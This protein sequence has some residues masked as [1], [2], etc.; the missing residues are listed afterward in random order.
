MWAVAWCGSPS[1]GGGCPDPRILP[2]ASGA[3]GS[4][5][6][7]LNLARNAPTVWFSAPWSATVLHVAAQDPAGSSRFWQICRCAASYE[8]DWMA[9]SPRK[10][11]CKLLV[12]WQLW[13]WPHWSRLPDH[14]FAMP[15]DDPHSF[16]AYDKSLLAQMAT[17]AYSVPRFYSLVQPLVFVWWQNAAR[18]PPGCIRVR[19]S[20]AMR[21]SFNLSPGIWSPDRPSGSMV[22]R[23]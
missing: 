5:F 3:R 22:V 8:L 23:C 14:S 7:L 1:L 18:L 2:R 16:A 21:A 11:A 9:L 20:V 17:I 13:F 6:W 4:A 15:E 12:T 19:I 10:V